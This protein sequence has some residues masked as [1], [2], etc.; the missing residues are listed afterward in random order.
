MPYFAG[1]EAY[2]LGSNEKR[3]CS[4]EKL[5]AYLSENIEFPPQAK[6][7]KIFGTVYVSF[8]V[9]TEGKVERAFVLKDI[10]GGC[11]NAAL[12]VVN[13]FPDWE[14]GF[15]EGKIVNVKL[16]L[17]VQFSFAEEG[18]YEERYKIFW[19]SLKGEQ[20][21]KQELLNNI[22]QNIQLL[23][24]FGNSVSLSSLRFAFQKKKKTFVGQ[25]SGYINPKLLKVLKK[26]RPGGVFSILAGFQKDGQLVEIERRYRVRK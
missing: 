18:A 12:K 11:G 16:N 21:T 6:E 5:I 7:E 20:T 10:G 23:D 1:C 13:S 26:T 8:V 17:P 4:N 14:P 19:G 9:N 3:K 25:S 24:E 15:H 2:M 22:D